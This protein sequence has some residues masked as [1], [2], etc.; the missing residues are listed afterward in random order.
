MPADTRVK[1]L[2]SY[3]TVSKQLQELEEELH[4]VRTRDALMCPLLMLRWAATACLMAKTKKAFTIQY[5]DMDGDAMWGI[6]PQYG[7]MD[8]DAMWG[9][10]PQYGDMDGDAMWGIAP[11]YGD[12]DGDAMWGIAPQYGDMDGDAMW[13][14]ADPV[15]E[16]ENDAFLKQLPMAGRAAG[17]GQQRAGG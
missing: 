2:S 1:Q 13:G 8:G 14:I 3:L 6:A 5:G 9:I 4:L 15:P 10:A 7:D 12:M 16:K 11:Q 17:V